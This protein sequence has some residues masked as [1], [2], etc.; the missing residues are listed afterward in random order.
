MEFIGFGE[1][2]KKGWER[3]CNDYNEVRN[4]LA[5]EEIS[6]EEINRVKTLLRRHN[7]LFPNDWNKRL[8]DKEKVLK[9]KE[10][11]KREKTAGPIKTAVPGKTVVPRKEDIKLQSPSTQSR[12][13]SSNE[14]KGK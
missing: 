6:Q 3:I 8:K 11:A 4:I 5:K 13:S 10:K 12:G 7:G 14:A 2:D 9:D 1:K